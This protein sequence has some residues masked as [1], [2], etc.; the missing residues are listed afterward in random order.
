MQTKVMCHC[1]CTFP[2]TLTISAIISLQPQLR[3]LLSFLMLTQVQILEILCF[4][5][6]TLHM[7]NSLCSAFMT[8]ILLMML[9]IM[10]CSS[11]LE[12]LAGMISFLSTMPEVGKNSPKMC[13]IHIDCMSTQMNP[14]HCCIGGSFSSNLL[15]MHG[16]TLSSHG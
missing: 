3:L 4:I 2:N 10:S 15:W 12:I 6:G 5:F 14:L 1:T 7:V 16:H 8:A 9:F 13:I 11:H